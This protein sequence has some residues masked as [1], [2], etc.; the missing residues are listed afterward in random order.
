M[1]A[2]KTPLISKMMLMALVLNLAC[3]VVIIIQLNSRKASERTPS[4]TSEI[5]PEPG[6]EAEIPEQASPPRFLPGRP[7]RKAF[8]PVPVPSRRADEEPIAQTR[9]ETEAAGERPTD[10]VTRVDPGVA[11]SQWP[12]QAG[13]VTTGRGGVYG[14]V[15]LEGTPPPEIPVSTEGTTCG[16]L[17]NKPLTTRHYLVTGDGRLANVLVY[18]KEGLEKL[19]FPI[20]TSRPTLGNFGCQFE[21]YMM[22]VQAG[23]TFRIENSDPIMHNVHATSEINRGFNF[24]LSKHQLV[25]KRFS[26]PEIFV[27]V[28]CDVH[29]WMFAYI[30]VLPHPFFAVTDSEGAFRFPNGLPPG[31]YLIAARHLKAGEGVR[32]VTIRDDQEMLVR[33]TLVVPNSAALASD[34]PTR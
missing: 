17:D 14:Y 22:G 16:R 9:I 13:S 11:M 3:L 12:A 7:I 4:L 10:A 34:A 27:R 18:V 15:W 20:S 29:P 28:T 26:L 19:K 6:R 24:S 8:S 31:K 2:V 21:P 33:L 5:I 32:Q 1:S 23:Q 25:E 30:G